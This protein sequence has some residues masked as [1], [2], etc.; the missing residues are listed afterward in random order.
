MVKSRP[1]LGKAQLEPRGG[2]GDGNREIGDGNGN[3]DGEGVP[4]DETGGYLTA[5]ASEPNGGP[6]NGKDTG[7]TKRFSRDRSVGGNFC[8][9]QGDR[10]AK[11]VIT[12]KSNRPSGKLDDER[13]ARLTAAELIHR[14]VLT[15][16][17]L[18]GIGAKD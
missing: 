9:P 14:Q 10:Y 15:E 18:E 13:D 12:V 8:H 4:G 11:R 1:L 6:G 2:I 17:G 5:R 3:G 7:F 16:D